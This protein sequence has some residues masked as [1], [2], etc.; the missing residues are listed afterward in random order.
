ML[1]GFLQTRTLLGMSV[2]Y[3]PLLKA[4]PRWLCLWCS[5]YMRGN[6]T[7]MY[8]T[9]YSQ[10]LN[11]ILEGMMR[12]FIIFITAV[13]MV[14]CLELRWM[15]ERLLTIT[16]ELESLR[17]NQ[18]AVLDSSG[19]IAREVEAWRKSAIGISWELD[20]FIE[21]LRDEGLDW[22]RVRDE[23]VLHDTK[24]LLEIMREME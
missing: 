9:I 5:N 10:L 11:F 18:E 17:Y 8:T 16:S 13:L 2:N 1:L 15:N 19:V 20:N 12:Y 6:D 23:K 22:V 4:L 14:M 7:L 3:T 24:E 21:I